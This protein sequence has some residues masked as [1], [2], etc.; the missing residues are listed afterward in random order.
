MLTIPFVSHPCI[1][2]S[3]FK[4]DHQRSVFLYLDSVN[5]T[6]DSKAF[7]CSSYKDFLDGNCLSCDRFGD[8]GCPVF[9][10]YFYYLLEMKN[11]HLFSL[12]K[13]MS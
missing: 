9:G 1:G 11:T 3:Y 4:C 12:F 6:C 2:G 7:P 13:I 8:A 10:W 5:Q